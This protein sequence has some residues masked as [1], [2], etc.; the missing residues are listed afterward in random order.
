[1]ASAADP[2][3]Q[4]TATEMVAPVVVGP[5][6]LGPELAGDGHLRRFLHSGRN[7]GF[8]TH[9]DGLV[10]LPTGAA[11]LTNGDGGT[12]LC[13]EIRRAVAAEYGWGE[14]GAPDP[15]RRRGPGRAAV[16]HG[17]RGAVRPPA[18]AGV[19]G[20]RAVQPRP[21]RAPAHAPLAD[22][23]FLDEE[24]GATLEV[25]RHDGRVARIAVLVDGV[26]LMAFDP[27]EGER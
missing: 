13:G 2:I 11:V 1:M 9:V 22:A 8:C 14:I 27:Q 5:F 24:T 10:E 12:T 6:G 26:E 16:V 23:T 18:A 15:A 3:S 4:A 17:S 21:L 25:E 7:E 19:R 20:R